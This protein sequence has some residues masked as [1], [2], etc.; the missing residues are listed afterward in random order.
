M[1]LPIVSQASFLKIQ[2]SY[3]VQAIEEKWKEH[4]GQRIQTIKDSS[5]EVVIAGNFLIIHHFIFRI[6][7]HSLIFLLVTITEKC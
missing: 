4:I 5:A 3:L 7:G 6:L 2:R 1:K